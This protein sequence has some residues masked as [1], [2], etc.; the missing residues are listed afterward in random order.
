MVDGKETEPVFAL[1]I[2][3][4]NSGSEDGGKMS[5]S[6]VYKLYIPP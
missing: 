3:G 5:S 2:P 1:G 4:W 6:Y